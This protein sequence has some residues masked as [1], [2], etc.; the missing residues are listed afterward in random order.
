[1]NWIGKPGMTL[2]ATYSS[3]YTSKATITLSS[4]RLH[5][6]V[7]WWL[8][9][10]SKTTMEKSR[11]Q[12]LHLA[13]G[14]LSAIHHAEAEETFWQQRLS[15]TESSGEN[16]ILSVRTLTWPV[17]RCRRSI[18]QCTV[19]LERLSAMTRFA[20]RIRWGTA[21]LLTR[22]CGR[23]L[24]A[25]RAYDLAMIPIGSLVRESCRKGNSKR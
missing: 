8:K 7:T 24:L 5:V 20:S 12:R 2:S 9:L 14:L 21:I 3:R 1:M 18:W 4:L 22:L 25:Y 11:Q 15:L 16:R 6:C 13:D 19:V 17:A 10:R 23:C